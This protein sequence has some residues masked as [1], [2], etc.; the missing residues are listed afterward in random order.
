MKCT[1]YSIL[2]FM[3][4]PSEDLKQSLMSGCDAFLKRAMHSGLNTIHECEEAAESLVKICQKK[5]TEVRPLKILLLPFISYS[6]ASFCKASC[7][8]MKLIEH[9]NL[10][11]AFR[12]Q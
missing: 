3:S 11:L 1:H 2:W 4:Q 9:E 8:G 10:T 12:P 6:K 5:G 7:R